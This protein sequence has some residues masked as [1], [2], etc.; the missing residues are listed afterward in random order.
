MSSDGNSPIVFLTLIAGRK[1]K[2]SL[3]T[4]L[5]DMGAR[6]TNTIYGKSSVRAN[7]S[8]ME[9][10]GF[11]PEEN[12]IIITCLLPREKANMVLKMLVKKFHFDKPNT[13]IAF[14]VAVECLS[15]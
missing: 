10:F 5:S 15:F 1:R 7:S 14:T 9:V 2:D 11:V 6:V 13:G 4:L 8:L 3:L 12:K